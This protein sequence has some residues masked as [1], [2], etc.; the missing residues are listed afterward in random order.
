MVTADE[1]ILKA[2]GAT[3]VVLWARFYPWPV[4]G[5]LI[6]TPSLLK[7]ESGWSKMPIGARS[8]AREIVVPIANVG[9]VRVE[10][11][12]SVRRLALALNLFSFVLLWP[13]YRALLQGNLTVDTESGTHHFRVRNPEMWVQAIAEARGQR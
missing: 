3:S 4:P 7:F 11:W 1:P 6:L 8:Y 9:D 12:P 10:T 5:A 2:S 13:G